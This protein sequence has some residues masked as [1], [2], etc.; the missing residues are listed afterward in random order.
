M[1]ADPRIL[2]ATAVASDADLIRELLSDEFENVVVSTNPEHAIEDFE[3]QRPEVLILAFNSLEKAER[4]YLGLY[5]LSSLIHALP[6]RT[7]I[8]CNKDDL[9]RVY[10]LCKKEYFDDY[11]LFWP[12]TY[13]ATRL[14]MAVHHALRLMASAAMPSGSEIAAQARRLAD[15]EAQLDRYAAHGGQQV[16]AA[17]SSLRQAERDIG[18]AL[19]RFSDKLSDGSHP[20]LVEVKDRNGLQRE[21]NRLKVEEIEKRFRIV[22]AAVQ[23]VRQWVSALKDD[24]TPQLESARALQSLAERFQPI[25]LVVEDDEFQHQI[26]KQMLADM[27]LDLVFATSGTEALA[28]LRKRRPDLILMDVGLPDIDGVETTRRLK[29]V[30]QFAKIPVVMITGHSEKAVVVESLKAGASDFA[31]KP[32][33]KDVLRAKVR[34]FLNGEYM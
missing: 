31:V 24:L 34:S 8:L 26:L 20:G 23:P 29:S 32:F 15:L 7:L 5:R 16:E 22:N 2:V 28:T 4:Y 13:D 1:N 18:A 12:M 14:L 3:K 6:H 30:E 9:R 33:D 10:E 19:D 27:N 25:V 21:I 11:I 17:S